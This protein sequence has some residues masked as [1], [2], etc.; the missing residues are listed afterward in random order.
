MVSIGVVTVFVTLASILAI[1][2]IKAAMTGSISD[3]VTQTV[4]YHFGGAVEKPVLL[5]I[6]L[7]F[8]GSMVALHT[9]GSRTLYAAARDRTIPAAAFFVQLSR[10]RRLPVMALAFTTAV[11]IVILLINLGASQVFQTLLTISVAGFFISYGFVV[12]SQLLLQ[13]RGLHRAGPFTLGGLSRV[14]TLVA[15]VWIVLELINVW[16]PRLPDA[17]WYQNWG[18]LLVTIILAVA[19]IVAY[20]L[21]PR[22]EISSEPVASGLG[23]PRSPTE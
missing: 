16:W 10:E 17:A 21:A 4:T 11:A 22:H 7:G 9:A 18:V 23:V 13:Q 1:P 6:A 12:I 14:V 15:A 2:D 20:T 19:G 8:I 3:P 5:M